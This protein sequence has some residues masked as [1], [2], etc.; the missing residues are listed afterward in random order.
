MH[1]TSFDHYMQVAALQQIDLFPGSAVDIVV[2]GYRTTSIW[3]SELIV[4][5]KWIGGSGDRSDWGDGK[6]ESK[7]LGIGG[8]IIGEGRDTL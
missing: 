5:T 2:K 7:G 6:G 1:P 3:V 8:V 4:K